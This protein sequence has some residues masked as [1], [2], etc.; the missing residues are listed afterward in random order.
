VEHEGDFRVEPI[1]ILDR[2]VK[3]LKKK[4]T[5]IVN[6]QW[7]CYDPEDAT[8]EHEKNMREEYPHF[9]VNFEENII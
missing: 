9:F 6:V 4:S 7:T 1:C 8:R 3:V 2:K 5:G